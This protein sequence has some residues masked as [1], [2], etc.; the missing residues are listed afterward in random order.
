MLESVEYGTP[1]GISVS[2]NYYPY[3]EE[4]QYSD[5]KYSRKIELRADKAV[6]D[7]DSPTVLINAHIYP[8]NSDYKDI[9]WKC[10][11]DNGVEV[12][13][14]DI[15]S[16]L[17]GAVISA[18]GDGKYKIRAA[19]NNGKDFPQVIS[20]LVFENT[21]FGNA[22]VSPYTF[23][24]ASLYNFSNRPLNIIEHAAVSVNTERIVTG[25]N[26]IDFGSYGSNELILHCGHSGGDKPVPV[27]IW[28]G[29]PDDDGELL[30]TLDFENNGLWNNFGPQRFVL[31]K[32]V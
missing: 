13:L 31:L 28:L 22:L 3:Y 11:L 16:I 18:R 21:G 17:D 32:K 23:I 7:A 20:E 15:K 25:F 12:G 27:E 19:C 14:S 2:D 29:N 24:S 30:D 5:E 26:N 9:E 4:L 8:E 10:V 1:V 6:L